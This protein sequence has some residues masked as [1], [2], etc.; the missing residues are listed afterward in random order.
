[1]SI[2]CRRMNKGLWWTWVSLLWAVIP[3]CTAIGVLFYNAEG[4][5]LLMAVYVLLIAQYAFTGA[6]RIIALYAQMRLMLYEYRDGVIELH[7][8]TVAAFGLLTS[9][10]IFATFM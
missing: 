3:T 8:F 2:V 1:M 7:Y 6:P 10:V 9:Q 4:I 5:N